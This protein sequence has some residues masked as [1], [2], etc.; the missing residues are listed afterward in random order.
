MAF[1]VNLGGVFYPLCPGNVRYVDEAIYTFINPDKKSE[2]SEIFNFSFNSSPD[3]VF[4]FNDIPGIGLNLLHAQ[5]NSL[6]G[7]IH[8][9]YKGIHHITNVHDLR[10][11]SDLP[12]PGH[13]RDVNQS[14]HALLNLHKCTIICQTDDAALHSCA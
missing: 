11:M 14:F 12:G 5:G 7:N 1:L 9:Q 6:F 13:L 2:L 8:I 3:R 10:G 4:F